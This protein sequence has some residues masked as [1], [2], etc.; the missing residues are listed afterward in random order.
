MIIVD[1]HCHLNMKGLNECLDDVIARA[2]A[3]DVKILQTICTKL[4]EFPSVLA[5][6]EKYENVY[7]SLGVHPHEVEKD[8]VPQVERLLD[9][10]ST[11]KVI[12][13][14]ETGLDYFYNHSDK[15]LQQESLLNH[16]AASRESGLPIIIHNRDSD[17]DMVNILQSEMKKG[18]FKGLIHCFTATE[19]LA[20]AV[21][22]LGMYISISGIITFKKSEAL[23]DVVKT[24]P[25]DR[26]LVETDSPYLAPEPMRGKTNEPAYTKYVVDCLAHLFS[27]TSKEIA[28]ITTANFCA[29]FRV[30]MPINSTI[31]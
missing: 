18:E 31:Q 28:E 14:G 24:L 11:P 10:A 7:C 9:L 22:E 20:K 13:L 26:L 12:G 3:S 2:V 4:S 30:E 19:K 15:K 21:L 5:I 23:R 8:G 16:I 1:S 29:L 25:L 17:D 6:A 27:R